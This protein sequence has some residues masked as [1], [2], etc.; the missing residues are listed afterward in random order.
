M[1]Q[2][3]SAHVRGNVRQGCISLHSGTCNVEEGCGESVD[4]ILNIRVNISVEEA[5]LFGMVHP[6]HL[7]HSLAKISY[8][9]HLACM[10]KEKSGPSGKL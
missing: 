2:R 9:M 8:A 3:Q 5:E 6:V 4:F 10:G 7:Y 1:A